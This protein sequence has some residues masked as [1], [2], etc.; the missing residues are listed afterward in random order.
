MWTSVAT[1]AMARQTPTINHKR[2]LIMP[3]LIATALYTCVKG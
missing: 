2:G 1:A 3:V